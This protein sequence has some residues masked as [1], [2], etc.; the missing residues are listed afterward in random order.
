MPKGNSE[1]TLPAKPR[2]G[3]ACNGCG[4]CCSIELCRVGEI[5]YP[6]AVAPCP[7]LK[8]SADGSRTY[9]ELVLIE[10][11]AGMIPLIA[12]GLGIGRGCSMPDAVDL[13]NHDE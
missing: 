5:A 13:E 8:L 11:E 3:E 2:Y 1:I 4:I 10:K 6:G 9:C 7:G 12:T